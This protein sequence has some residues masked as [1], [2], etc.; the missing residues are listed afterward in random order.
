LG[1]RKAAEK[2]FLIDSKIIAMPMVGMPPDVQPK[3]GDY[4]LTK[5]N[6]EAS[7]EKS[8]ELLGVERLNVLCAHF[9]DPF[10]GIEES[11][12]TFDEEF[13]RGRFKEVR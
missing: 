2:G 12:K 5:A 9:M 4:T 8:L 6:I 7:S 1:Q 10:T 13:W 11:A 3:P